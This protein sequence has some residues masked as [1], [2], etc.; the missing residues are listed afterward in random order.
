MF[1][2]IPELSLFIPKIFECL[3][4]EVLLENKKSSFSSIYRSPSD[5]PEHISEFND[6][7]DHLLYN[8]SS[9]FQNS[10]ICLDSNF[11]S[12]IP[13]PNIHHAKYYT[14]IS[15]NGFI[16]C[17]TKATRIS[18]NSSSLIDHII[19]NSSLE[20]IISGTIISDIS[21]HFMTFIQLPF[22][23]SCNLPR[24]VESRV[25]SGTNIGKFRDCLGKLSWNNVLTCKNVDDSYN[26]FWTD[27]KMLYDQNFPV[28]KTKFNK[29]LH[30]ICNYMTQGL[31][32]SRQSKIK[33]HKISIQSPNS[34]N[35]ERYKKI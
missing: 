8:L 35:I 17:I 23:Q 12:L 10:Y 20:K 26:L 18:N 33:L 11:N 1:K 21:D 31:L 13:L 7:L 15:E 30:K 34:S 4:I 19:T 28:K 3:T 22:V 14:T 9:S 29:N 25:F 6:H 27:F 5:S 24:Y 16:Q 2:I 32:V